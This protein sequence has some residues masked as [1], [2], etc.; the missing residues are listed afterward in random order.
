MKP[1]TILVIDD[2]PNILN[3]VTAYL[4]AEGY[5]THTASNGPS[6]LRYCSNF[7]GN[8]RCM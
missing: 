7:A 2:E 3:I 1:A 4:Q 8:Q 6:G 5:T